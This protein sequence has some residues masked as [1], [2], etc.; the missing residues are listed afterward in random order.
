MQVDCQFVEP[1]ESGQFIGFK[2]HPDL[3]PVIKDPGFS[4]RSN[5][6]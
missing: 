4:P 6:S 5:S 3:E 1:T 2:I